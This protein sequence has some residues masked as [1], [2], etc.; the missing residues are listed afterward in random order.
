MSTCP[1]IRLEDLRHPYAWFVLDPPSRSAY[2]LEA[3]AE[4]AT[5]R[6]EALRLYE[7]LCELA[8]GG[9]DG[10]RVAIWVGAYGF[11]TMRENPGRRW[12]RGYK[13]DVILVVFPEIDHD[14]FFTDDDVR[15]VLADSVA[16]VRD[17]HIFN[18][19][20]PTFDQVENWRGPAMRCINTSARYAADVSDADRL[21]VDTVSQCL[22]RIA[23]RVKP[24][25][26]D[27]PSPGVPQAGL[28]IYNDAGLSLHKHAETVTYR[29]CRSA[30][31][32]KLFF[33]VLCA[34]RELFTGLS[35]G[36]LYLPADL[37]DPNFLFWS[38]RVQLVENVYAQT[39]FLGYV[40]TLSVGVSDDENRFRLVSQQAGRTELC[41]ASAAGGGSRRR[42]SRRHRRRSRHSRRRSRHS[43]RRSRRSRSL[44]RR[45]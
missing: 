25:L 32:P 12:T 44:H 21:L 43:R 41:L 13:Y 30:F 5:W 37:E 31:N 16:D 8:E 33:A 15:R 17:I 39:T 6:R 27:V 18:T 20:F 3:R 19:P 38:E 24:V 28:T 26:D 22:V 9:A 4:E 42:H 14:T 2:A 10:K 36:D 34:I 40:M 23:R 11:M 45:R 1:K 35:I 29:T 7:M